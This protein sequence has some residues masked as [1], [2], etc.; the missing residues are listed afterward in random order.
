M[1]RSEIREGDVLFASRSNDLR[2][3]GRKAYVLDAKHGWRPSAYYRYYRSEPQLD[4]EGFERFPYT[5][6]APDRDN[7]T[8]LCLV[9]FPVWKN[10][11]IVGHDQ[12]VE[13]V[14]TRD[15]R[16]DYHEI[17]SRLDREDLARQMRHNADEIKRKADL[18]TR[19]S[20]QAAMAKAGLNYRVSEYGRGTDVTLNLSNDEAQL[21]AVLLCRATVDTL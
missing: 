9:E 13:I 11:T 15:L 14:A 3:G 10:G 4:E 7:A 17:Q 19:K 2:Y 20:T 1:K 16:G 18:A 5:P 21:L 8:V 6:V 12:R